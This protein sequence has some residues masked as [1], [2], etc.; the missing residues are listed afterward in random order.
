RL[1]QPGGEGLL[2]VG[3]APEL[4]QTLDAKTNVWRRPAG[5]P[6]LDDP[7][8]LFDLVLPRFDR[9]PRDIVAFGKRP[10]LGKTDRLIA[11]RRVNRVV[12][13]RKIPH[14][15]LLRLAREQRIAG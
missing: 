10:Q 5:E 8:E 6:R 9:Q 2:A 1:A 7:I 12:A 4:G 3:I 14:S 11:A 13:D 15:H